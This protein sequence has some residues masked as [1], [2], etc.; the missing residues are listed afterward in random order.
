MPSSDPARRLRALGNV[1]RHGYDDI[2]DDVIWD[3]IE[4]GLTPLRDV[5]VAELTRLDEGRK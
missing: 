1:L 5:C 2:H 3:T 4:Y